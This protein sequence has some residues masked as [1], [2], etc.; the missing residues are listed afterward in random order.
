MGT[1]KQIGT[2]RKAALTNTA[3]MNMNTELYDRIMATTP[4]VLKIETQAPLY[5]KA[6]DTEGLCVNRIS[7]SAATQPM[8]EKDAERDKVFSFLNSQINS[9][10][11]C[12]DKTMQQAA[13]QLEALFN[14]YPATAEKAY[15]EET[16]AIDGLLRDMEGEKM[17]AAAETLNLTTYFTQLKTLNDEY[18]AMDAARTD[19]YA[20]RVKID[21]DS[22]RKVVD[23]LWA[24]I[25]Q[26]VNAV[27]VLEPSDAVNLFIDTVN[28]IFRKYKDLIA[29]KGGSSS[30]TPSENAPVP[31][32][33]SDAPVMDEEDDYPTGEDG[34]PELM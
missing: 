2:L 19:E 9:F 34:I 20:S 8:V 10:M 6:L 21:T 32:P 23:N 31:T 17:K 30:S 33:D 1:V 28:Q 4:A 27:A 26:R 25:A 15:S 13:A 14:A 11:N 29:A 18:K 7:K 24:E 12:P 22:A 3:H 16:G 5:R